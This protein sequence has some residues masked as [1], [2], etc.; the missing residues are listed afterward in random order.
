MR[1]RVLNKTLTLSGLILKTVAEMGF[2]AMD[3]FFPAKHPT[4]RMW[5]S[6]LGLDSSYVFSKLTFA[7]ILRRLQKQGLVQQGRGGWSITARGKTILSRSRH[8]SSA[9]HTMIPKKDGKMR[10][11]IFDIPE[12]QKGVRGWLR[13]ELSGFGFEMLQKSVWKGY[14]PVPEPFARDLDFFDLRSNVHIFTVLDEGT[15]T[16]LRYS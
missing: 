11:V 2:A 4:A 1:K 12:K 5:R 8:G 15:L 6:I 7:M 16:A 14:T 9:V 10:L 13:G 3:A